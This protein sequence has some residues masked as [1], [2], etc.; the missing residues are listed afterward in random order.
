MS[1]TN[2]HFRMFLLFPKPYSAVG[3][4]KLCLNLALVLVFY[5]CTNSSTPAGEEDG[6]Q[7]SLSSPGGNGGATNQDPFNS[8]SESG[9][10]TGTN[11]V[12]VSSKCDTTLVEGEQKSR[13]DCR[14]V[15]HHPLG[16]SLSQ[17]DAVGLGE[18]VFSEWTLT[19]AI[20]NLNGEEDF[21][22][23]YSCTD[24]SNEVTFSCDFNQTNSELIAKVSVSITIP[25]EVKSVLLETHNFFVSECDSVIETSDFKVSGSG[26]ASKPYILCFPHQFYSYVEN[27][28]TE[29]PPT[30]LLAMHF[31][32]GRDLDFDVDG[33]YD[34]MPQIATSTDPYMGTFD[35]NGFTMKNFSISVSAD[36]FRGG[37]FSYAEDATIKNIT[38]Y[39]VDV[40]SSSLVD[41]MGIVLG[42]ASHS[43]I[44]RVFVKSGNLTSAAKAGGI[45]GDLAGGSIVSD[46][47]V[48]GDTDLTSTTDLGGLVDTVCATCSVLRSYSYATIN[49]MIRNGGLVATNNGTIADSYVAG[50]VSGGMHAGG[51]AGQNSGTIEN[52]YFSGAVSGASLNGG[53]AGNNTGSIA[54]SYFNT[55]S[56]VLGTG[57]GS[58]AGTFGRTVTQMRQQSTFDGWNFTTTW[59]IVEGSS[60]PFLITH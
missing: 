22:G 26:T 35:G 17:I 49:S 33:V 57:S 5:S 56:T 52:S 59:D 41:V 39:N 51:I 14:L 42:Q 34:V 53:I 46:S 8:A 25:D 36:L 27:V 47:G 21:P 45:V 48:D 11:L 23:D 40:S 37:I 18:G 24:S 58:D 10:V 38:F 54:G 12:D 1:V 15:I 32:L 20:P 2:K 43:F 55:E 30:A 60:F 13:I 7:S 29:S 16:F 9:Y 19:R 6:D 31:R 50:N 3:W 28:H 44:S 4:T